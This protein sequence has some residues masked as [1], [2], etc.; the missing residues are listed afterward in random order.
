[1][2]DRPVFFVVGAA[3]GVGSA[4]CRRLHARGFELV[5]AGRNEPPLTALASEVGGEVV[6]FDARDFDRTSAAMEQA[7]A[8]HGRLDGVV[9][10][11]GSILL[12]PA[13]LTSAADW[14][15]TLG[16]N[17][18]TAFSVVRAA[19]P[20]LGK[21]GGGA[22]VLVSSA[23]ARLGLANHEAVAAA[24]AGVVGLALSAAAT[25][26]S[27]GV[28]VNVVSPGLVRTPLAERI[29]SNEASLKASQGMHALGRIGEPDDVARVLEFLLDPA[30]SW[31]TGQVYGVDGGLGTVRSRA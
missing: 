9:N 6:A 22:L 19:A 25:Y 16:A 24:K 12:K 1:M 15:Q 10:L 5:L 17:L 2:S 3:G 8:R 30:Q 29:V 26:A 18:G 31:I 20:L 11:A 13:H 7:H 14:E 23:A 4:L 28:R 27:R 21:S